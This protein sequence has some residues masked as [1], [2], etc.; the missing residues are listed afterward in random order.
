MG[1]DERPLLTRMTCL[2]LAVVLGFTMAGCRGDNA[3]A[4]A[5]SG[6]PNT[7]DGIDRR[8]EGPFDCLPNE[9]GD[10]WDC[11]EVQ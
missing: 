7:P 11:E 5:P 3:S 10:G 1:I 6:A 9:S 4:A 8:P 2:L